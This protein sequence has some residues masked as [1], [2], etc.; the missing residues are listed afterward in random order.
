M[1]S[2]GKG[3]TILMEPISGSLEGFDELLKVLNT[4]GDE[5]QINNLL[6][7]SNR[8]AVKPLQRAMKGLQFPSRLTKGISIRAALVDGA[9]HPNAVVVGPI[10]DVF[11]IRWLDR[12]T[13]ERYT[14]AGAYRGKIQGKNIIESLVDSEASKIQ[15]D[16]QTKYAED[17]VKVTAKDVKRINRNK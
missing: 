8:E 11:P 7:K 10:S 4:L 3:Y 1:Y 13:K 14:K 12:G 5:K 15:K 6:K 16:A 17:L 9:K 2:L